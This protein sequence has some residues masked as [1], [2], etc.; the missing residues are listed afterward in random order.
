[1]LPPANDIHV[2]YDASLFSWNTLK[3]EQTQIV[4][5]ASNL[6]YWK[7]LVI[8]LTTPYT[9]YFYNFVFYMIFLCFFAYVIMRRFCLR[10]EWQEYLGTGLAKA[11]SLMLIIL[12]KPVKS[13]HYSSCYMY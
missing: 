8:F 5:T 3:Q 13:G 6:S 9:A 4:T 10:P 7:K 1:M 2:D 11:F 12:R